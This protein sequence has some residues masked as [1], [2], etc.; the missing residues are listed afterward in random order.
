MR[1]AIRNEIELCERELAL[2]LS[3]LPGTEPWS[4]EDLR[5]LSHLIVSAMVATAESILETTQHPEAEARVVTTAR[6][7]L[8][9]VLIGALHWRSRDRGAA[10]P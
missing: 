8:R 5:V 1:E 3:R 10:L 4:V 2:D 6:T 7:Q 9:M